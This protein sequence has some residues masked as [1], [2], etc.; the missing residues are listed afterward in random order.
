[1]LMG[2]CSPNRW[3]ALWIETCCWLALYI[4]VGFCVARSDVNKTVFSNCEVHANVSG[5]DFTGGFVGKLAFGKVSCC[6]V[7]GEV[8]GQDKVGGF[9]GGIT[10]SVYDEAKN[11]SFKHGQADIDSCAY[12]GSIKGRNSVGG[13]IGGV[14]TGDSNLNH[15]SSARQMN[16]N[17]SY[18]IGDITAT[19]NNVG[20]LIGDYNVGYGD[21]AGGIISDSYYSGTLVGGGKV[22][23][24]VGNI[25]LWSGW[26]PNLTIKNSLSIGTLRGDSV[27][28]GLVGDIY[29]NYVGTREHHTGKDI[30]L[31]T[32]VA[33]LAEFSSTALPV[34]RIYGRN[35]GSYFSTGTLGTAEDNLALS[36]MKVSVSGVVQEITDDEQNGTSVGRTGL[37]L[38]A[39]YVAHGWDFNNDWAI[40]ETETYPYKPWQTTPPYVESGLTSQSTTVA[41]KSVDG[42]TVYIQVGERY[43][44]SVQCSDNQFSFTVPA[45]QSGE[46]VRL[47]A[48][49]DGK[50]QSPYTDE[51]VSYPGK[52]TE[53]DPYLVY[54]A[55]D[56][57]GVYKRGHYKLMN[58]IDLTEWINANS[59]VEGWPAVGK[60]GI[61]E[62][63][64]DGGGHTVSGLWSKTDYE[65]NGLF[66]NFPG[67]SIQDLTVK[68]AEGKSVDGGV[69][70]GI[71]IGRIANATI[72]NVTVEGSVASSSVNAKVGGIA[73]E[74]NGGSL[75]GCQ[76]NVAI[77]ASG[78]NTLAGGL[79]GSSSAA[80]GTSWSQG[81][82][83][84]TGNSA[85]AGGL[86]GQ[87]LAAGAVK[88]CYSLADASSKLYSAG[89]VA[90]SY[91]A[92]SSSYAKGNVSSLY[93]G[94]GVVGY[95]D[96][97]SASTSGCV[98]GNPRIDISDQGGWSIRVLGGFK[99]GSAQPGENNYALNTM[100]LSVN[101]V[102]KK[103][104]DNILDGY[105]KTEEVLE[106]QATYE[107][108]GW[109]FT[110]V[111][112][113]DEGHAW[114]L[115][116]QGGVVN[117]ITVAP[118][119]M[120]TSE[121]IIYDLQGRRVY[122]PAK[123]LYIV[124][125]R[126]VVIR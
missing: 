92:V 65:Y 89:L 4:G 7:Y 22:G 110:N 40:Q 55:S 102:T 72:S 10:E 114:P 118:S 112:S 121:N 1:M 96:G 94:A 77:T 104:S 32:S 86:I 24:L 107:A 33:A 44:A 58:N 21:W 3:C 50:L 62:I 16:V 88:D 43:T 20:G 2:V 12:Y 41:G 36:T 87:N 84:L 95:N 49:S 123:G 71:L 23:G 25:Y 67:G 5:G 125:G 73:G 93:Y 116:K 103:A 19:G 80:V 31:K 27:M 68:T 126:K 100:I 9:V 101:G 64:F 119:H 117:G 14:D 69:Y 105:A 42:G 61:S 82:V 59:T 109:D 57:Q 54:T 56:L 76:A 28:G 75:A 74:T 81:S 90:Y 17:N 26:E 15:Y 48:V 45:L 78:D 11:S 60:N 113:I 108:L 98:A 79:V 46:R 106:R 70:A 35:H 122:K 8:S 37:K 47:Y 34:G 120:T 38:K 53:A 97:A 99:N 85:Y 91:G 52:G 66:S 115:L 6:F 63:Y 13:Y 83:N 124:N 111:W 51:T 29:C 30:I 18:V 39:N